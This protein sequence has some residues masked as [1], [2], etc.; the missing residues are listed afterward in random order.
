M[1]YTN[2]KSK[3]SVRAVDISV[4]SVH[5]KSAFGYDPM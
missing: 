4:I 5:N 2:K 1:H 3:P